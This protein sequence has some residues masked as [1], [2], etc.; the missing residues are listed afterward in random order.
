MIFSA[1]TSSSKNVFSFFNKGSTAALPTD[2]M[3][4]K[5]N[6]TN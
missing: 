1:A 3:A 5:T 4:S 6:W 2:L